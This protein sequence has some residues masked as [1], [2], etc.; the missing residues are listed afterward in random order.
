MVVIDLRAQAVGTV[1]TNLRA[2]ARTIDLLWNE[3]LAERSGEAV[4]LGQASQAIHKALIA[5]KSAQA[6]ASRPETFTVEWESSFRPSFGRIG[7][8]STAAKPEPDLVLARS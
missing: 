5:L 7:P 3:A 1:V 2:A 4:P 6:P 8:P